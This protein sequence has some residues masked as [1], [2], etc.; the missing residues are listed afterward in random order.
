MESF[1]E[2]FWNDKGS[3]FTERRSLELGVALSFRSLKVENLA[4][5]RSMVYLSLLR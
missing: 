1:S 4:I 2:I 3:S 5:L